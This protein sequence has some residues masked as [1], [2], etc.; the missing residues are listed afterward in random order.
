MILSGVLWLIGGSIL[1]GVVSIG[2]GIVIVIFPNVLNYIVGIYLLLL[3][4]WLWL[5]ASLII[6]GI[7]TLV[8]G[9]VVLVFP[10]ILNYI[11]A[12][13]LIAAGVIA[14]GHYYGWF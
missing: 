8:A 3:G 2:F 4:L 7:I 10:A 9:V 14:I 6:A 12:L 11:F 5:G 13:Y 1:P